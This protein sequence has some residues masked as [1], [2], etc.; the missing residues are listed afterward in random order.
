MNKKHILSIKQDSRKNTTKLMKLQ[1]RISELKLKN[2]DLIFKL[3]EA[4][5]DQKS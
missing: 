2:G 4:K 5:K 3:K 1:N